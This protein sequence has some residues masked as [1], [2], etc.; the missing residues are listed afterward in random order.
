MREVLGAGII[1]FAGP[2]AR[3]SARDYLRASGVGGEVQMSIGVR[4]GVAML[5]VL[6]VSAGM[7]T[8]QEAV[9]IEPPPPTTG[10]GGAGGVVT[11]PSPLNLNSTLSPPPS[12]PRTS[13]PNLGDAAATAPPPSSATSGETGNESVPPTNSLLLSAHGLTGNSGGE[14]D[15]TDAARQTCSGEDCL[16]SCPS[17]VCPG[18]ESEKCEFVI[19]C[20]AEIT[21]DAVS[22][23]EQC[24]EQYVEHSTFDKDGKTT[25]VTIIRVPVGKTCKPPPCMN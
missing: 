17:D 3:F 4:L 9:R 10:P 12:A 20:V 25:P 8:A 15:I 22:D 24:D 21:A 5:A 1:F 23:D 13:S 7:A 2:F 14:C 16:L 19:D 6:A 11:T 18:Q